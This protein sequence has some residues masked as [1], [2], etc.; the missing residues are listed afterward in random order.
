[1]KDNFEFRSKWML[2]A[3]TKQYFFSLYY[4]FFCI[5]S[6]C[7]MWV[8]YP[9]IVEYK[10]HVLVILIRSLFFF[11]LCSWCNFFTNHVGYLGGLCDRHLFSPPTYLY[12]FFRFFF[13]LK[14]QFSFNVTLRNAFCVG[15]LLWVSSTFWILFGFISYLLLLGSMIDAWFCVKLPFLS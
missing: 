5:E 14:F 13:L 4:F 9:V 2:Y 1:M 11:Q 12:V 10:P 3:Q 15:V 8:L 7:Q 6:I